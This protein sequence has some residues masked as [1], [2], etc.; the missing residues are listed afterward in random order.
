MM[1]TPGGRV[2]VLDGLHPG[3]SVRKLAPDR[4]ASFWRPDLSFDGQRVL[5]CMKRHDDPAFHL[6]EIGLEG[7]G[8]RQITD[9]PYDD[10]DPIYLP[11][12]ASCSAARGATPTSAACPTPFLTSS[13]AAT[14]TGA[15][16]IS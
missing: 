10:L 8:L 7:T 12:G 2:L 1:A 14:P 4:P 15:I 16:S 9:G 3:G 5:F 11:D 6:Y 13:R